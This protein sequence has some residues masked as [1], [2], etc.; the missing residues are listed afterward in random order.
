[1]RK[2]ELIWFGL[3]L[4]LGGIYVHFF[5]HLFEK[6]QIGIIPRSAP[7]RQGRCGY[8]QLFLLSMAII[9]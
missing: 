6:P 3:L 5:T 2:K 7:D 1:M 9:S 8:Y 4:V